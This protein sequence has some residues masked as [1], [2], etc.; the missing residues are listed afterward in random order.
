MAALNIQETKALNDA[1]GV[2]QNVA[3]KGYDPESKDPLH[4]SRGR[5]LK[6]AYDDI[7]TVWIMK[8]HYNS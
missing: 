2:I 1:M 4:R 7:K 5:A 3:N 8:G 6:K